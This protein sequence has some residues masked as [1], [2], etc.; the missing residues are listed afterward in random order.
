MRYI[1]HLSIVLTSLLSCVF[2]FRSPMRMATKER[3][4]W[5]FGRFLRTASFY[6]ALRPR[7]PFFPRDTSSSTLQKVAIKPRTTLWKAN[8][9]TYGIE[10]GPLDDV[11]MGGASKSDLAPG[12][13][14]NGT[15]KGFVTTANNGGFVGI[16]TKVFKK[17]LDVSEC[18]GITVQLIGDG[19]RYKFIVRDDSD[20]NGI[21]WSQSFDTIP[22]K[23][24]VIQ[25]P[26]QKF[27]PTQFARTMV[28]PRAF[29]AAQMQAIQISLS[30]FEYD[31][32]LNPKFTEGQ[33]VL[34]IESIGTY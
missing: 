22:N 28:L 9:S 21:A 20:W 29:N 17:A 24:I 34:N 2:S 8:D 26:L 30:K 13:S 31:G 14:F 16:R 10:W 15:W 1:L 5:E 19:N 11:V 32:G 27:I 12:E 7:L 3:K 25:L 6:G 18:T 33:F 4:P 23:K